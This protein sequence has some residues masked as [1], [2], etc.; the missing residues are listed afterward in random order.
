MQYEMQG[1]TITGSWYNPKTGD[2]F[3]VR[4]AM[5][6]D[7]NMLI[8]TTDGRQIGLNQIEGYIQGKLPSGTNMAINEIKEI[9]KTPIIAE[10][11]TSPI[12]TQITQPASLGNIN[13]PRIDAVGIN[14]TIIQRA[15][16]QATKPEIS[17]KINWVD[18]PAD[19]I[20]M[21]ISDMD[22]DLD[23]IIEWASKDVNVKELS[24]VV[25]SQINKFIKSNI[26]KE[27]LKALE[28][29]EEPKSEKKTKKPKK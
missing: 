6:E 27:Y 17:V 3:T 13:G 5:F 28:T 25:K 18:W 24:V 11:D 7:N 12:T 2:S 19:K 23:D 29:P 15:L 8:M 10:L 26:S 21:L 16:R 1:P 22:I 14:D 4:D 9:S 20:N